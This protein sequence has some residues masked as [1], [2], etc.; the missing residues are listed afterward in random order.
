MK[1]RYLILTLATLPALAQAQTQLSL[2]ENPF[3]PSPAVNAAIT[4]ALPNSFRYTGQEGDELVSAIARH[5]GVDKDQIIPGDVLAQ[6]GIYLGV[7]GGKGGEFIYSVPGY[8]ALVDAAATV[9][10]VVISV[11]LNDKK[12]NDLAAIAAKIGPNTQAIYLVNPHNPSGTVTDNKVFYDFL[13]SASQKALIVV[14]EAYLEF[15]DDFEGRTAVNNIKAGDNVVVFRT[16]AKA[17]GL[18]G[19][20]FGYAVAPK[21]VADYLKKQGLGGVHD[22]NRISVAAVSASLA[23]ATYIKT[24]H[25]KV[26]AERTKWIGVLDELHLKHTESQANFVFF[27]IGKP[28]NEVAAKFKQEGIIIARSFAPYAT[29]IRITI[30]LPE[31]NSKAQR[32][33]RQLAK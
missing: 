25:D 16:F 32:V 20:A 28:Y 14:D 7:K 9:G 10:G 3:G 23:D 33:V 6:L 24:V 8:P 12:E 29:W 2:N 1:L 27:D 21:P 13:H 17:Y 26:N 18:A 22:L 11:P 30:G 15:S 5:E 31:E 4:K 19:L